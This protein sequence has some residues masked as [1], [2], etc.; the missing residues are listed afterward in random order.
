LTGVI[1]P[2]RVRL[3]LVLPGCGLV[4]ETDAEVQRTSETGVPVGH[5][6][7]EERGTPEGSEHDQPADKL[8]RRGS[9]AR[10]ARLVPVP[11]VAVPGVL[12]LHCT[13]FA[14]FLCRAALPAE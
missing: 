3:V 8:C 14:A 9:R 4:P 12:A 6:R 10:V 11:G 7:R 1:L 2:G 5:S 13:P